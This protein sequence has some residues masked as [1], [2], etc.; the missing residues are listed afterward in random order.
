[1]IMS[2]VDLNI[3]MDKWIDVDHLK[4]PVNVMKLV[5]DTLKTPAAFNFPLPVRVKDVFVE[6]DSTIGKINTLDTLSFMENVMKVDEMI[7]LGNVT[8]SKLH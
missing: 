6:A 2:Y 8:F 3:Q 7:S 1:M 4:G 5:V